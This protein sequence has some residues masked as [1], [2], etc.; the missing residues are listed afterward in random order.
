MIQT[1]EFQAFLRTEICASQTNDVQAADPISSKRNRERRQVFADRGTALHQ[2]QRAD[3]RELVHE[4]I[5]GNKRAILHYDVAGQQD[6]IGHDHMIA[7]DTVMA[8]M[9]I[10]HHEIVRTDHGFIGEC[11]GPVHREVFAK[12]I[13]VADAQARRFA[14]VFQI[15]RIVADDTTGMELVARADLGDTR[16][17]NMRADHALGADLNRFVDD[18]VGTDPDGGIDF[19][20]RVND[21]CGMNHALKVRKPAG[22]PSLKYNREFE[23]PLSSAPTLAKDFPRFV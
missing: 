8:D 15:L 21:R 20:L 1:F 19:G 7:N 4:A 6:A 3:A 17:V 16:N 5:A 9:R 22:L 11:G 23:I 18:G 2:R 13:A 14:F 12:D 10:G